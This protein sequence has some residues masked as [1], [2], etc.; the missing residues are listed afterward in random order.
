MSRLRNINVPQLNRECFFFRHVELN[1]S[2][3]VMTINEVTMD[4]PQIGTGFSVICWFSRSRLSRFTMKFSTEIFVPYG[5]F[6]PQ[7]AFSEFVVSSWQLC[8]TFFR[9]VVEFVI[10][11][12]DQY[13]FRVDSSRINFWC[14]QRF[15]I[16]Q[17]WCQS[18]SF[19]NSHRTNS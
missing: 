13:F 18:I 14:I 3:I 6:P 5:W 2:F 17:I 12:S 7:S 16:F 9:W 8:C 11:L 15:Q 4:R 10:F 19:Q 1:S